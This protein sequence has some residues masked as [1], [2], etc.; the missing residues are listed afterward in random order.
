[1][2]QINTL[3]NIERAPPE[4]TYLLTLL[5]KYFTSRKELQ[6]VYHKI[7]SFNRAKSISE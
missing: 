3:F 6:L 1:M 7:F 4:E 5:S 2:M